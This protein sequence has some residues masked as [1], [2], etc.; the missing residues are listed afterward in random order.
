MDTP[1]EP[2]LR[3][4]GQDDRRRARLPRMAEVVADSLRSQILDGALAVVPQLDVLIR[5]YDVGPP[6][7]REALR[8]LETEGLITVRRG[9]VGGAD[10]HMPTNKRVAY[11]LSLVLQAT[12]TSLADVGAALRQLSPVCAA[13]CAERRDRAESL[14]P[15]LRQLNEAQAKAMGDRLG[16][17][18][19]TDE[20]HALLIE[21]CG[22]QTLVQ[23][24]GA[25]EH[26]WASIALDVL[27]TD[28]VELAPDY[29]WKAALR[30]HQKIVDAIEEG[31]A[32]RVADLAR[33]HL[34]GT[35]AYMSQVDEQRRVSASV[36]HRRL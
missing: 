3:A 23:V 16:T 9:K 26:V 36:V 31:D 30:E 18:R 25:L 14:V 17:M 19:I 32:Q 27:D 21:E 4:M 6:A 13:L 11:T 34:T 2:P 15:R 1:I 5:E 28:E 24:V 12:G 35:H 8:I 10:V 20:F 29:L 33:R 7:A 22:N